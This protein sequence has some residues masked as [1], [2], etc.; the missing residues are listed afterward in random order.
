ME[1]RPL[2]RG[3]GRDS[4]QRSRQHE[5]P[6]GVPRRILSIWRPDTLTSDLANLKIY[7]KARDLAALIFPV[8]DRYPK[9]QQYGGLASEMRQACLVLLKAIV[10]ANESHSPNTVRS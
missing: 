5:Q 3:V 8:T 6:Q 7:Q 2:L 9:P 1:R 4:A 10:V